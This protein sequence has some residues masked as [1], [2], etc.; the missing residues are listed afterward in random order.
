[1]IKEFFSAKLWHLFFRVRMLL[2]IPLFFTS[3][4]YAQEKTVTGSVSDITGMP[5][6]GVN[7][8]IKGTSNGVVSDISGN[9]TIKVP[10]NNA[11]LTFTYVGYENQEITVGEQSTIKV[12]LNEN[13]KELDQVVVIGYGTQKKS[14]LTGSVSSVT[15]KDIQAT[16]V[17]RIDQALEGRAAGVNVVSATGMPGG[18]SN[19]QIRGVSSINGFAPLVVIDGIPG[20]DM[21]KISP[22]DIESIEVLK[23]AAS[24]AIYGSNGGNGVILI[25]TKRGKA[26]SVTTRVNIY[27][28]IQQVEKTI[29]MMNTRQWNQLYTAMNG[30]PFIF[31]Q[32]SLNM[33]TDWQKAIY[34][35]AL[36]NN[37]DVNITGGNDRS[38]FSIGA[39]Y[40]KQEGLVRNTGYNR[41]LLSVSSLT[42]IAKH[43]K[44]DAVVRFSNDQTT[45]PA[46]WQYQNV[47]NNFTTFPALSMDPYLKPYDANGKWSVSPIGA[48]NPFVG[49]D[50]K[51]DQ[52]GKDANI[53]GNVGLNIEFIKGL[54]YTLRLSG[55]EDN[56]ESWN[57]QPEYFSWANDA[58]PM[59]KLTQNWDKG[60]SWTIQN[61]AT[62]NKTILDD[63]NISLMAGMESSD[64]W[65]YHMNGFRQDFASSNPNLLY[66]DNSLDLSSTSQIIGGS[67]K[68]ATSAAYYGRINYDYKSMILAQ[69][70]ARRDGESNFGPYDKWGNFYSGSVGFKFTEL[71]VVKDLNIFSFGKIR[72]GVGQSGQFQG[73]SYWPYASTILS[74]DVMDY[75]FDN[76][77]LSS[78]FAP[79]QVPNPSLHWETV[80]TKNFGA[81]LGFFKDQ[82]NISIDYF[83][84]DNTNMIQIQHVNDVAGTFYISAGGAEF[85]NTG[86][87]STYPSVNFGSVSNKGIELTLDYKKVIGDVKINFGVNLTYQVN[88]ITELATD[89]VSQGAVHDLGGLTVSKVGEPIGEF[90]GYRFNGL[91]KQGDKMVYNNKSKKYVFADQ[92]YYVNG[93]DTSYA[94]AN[95]KAGDARWVDANHDGLLNGH[96][97]EYLGSYIPPYVFGFSL[98]MEY[99]GI[100]FSAFFQGVYGNQIFD[101]IKR[102]TY[103][104]E[105]SQNHAAEFANRYH[106]PVIYN[107]TT[108]DPGNTTSNMPNIGAQNWGTPSTLYIENGSY[109]RLRTLTLGYTLPVAW[110]SK[111][112][113]DKFRL[114]FIG[115]NLLTLTKYSGYDPEI[116]QSDP[117][118][119]GIDIGGYPQARMYTFGVNI[120][121]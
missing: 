62:Y 98:G 94:Q 35:T 116:S 100:D 75:A 65:D 86:I 64:W 46:E 79:V 118:L 117:K 36:Q 41:L 9:F 95:A 11:I 91:F 22:S 15:S 71:Q 105:T 84:K 101:G 87:Q 77:T 59:S 55:T 80:T 28:G 4:L 7:V 31:S 120:D 74:V 90:T 121:F 66:F 83:T 63:H 32:D 34:R 24:A 10:D 50:E 37:C 14:D 102:F 60:Y 8:V 73:L 49:I 45:G 23:D 6:P 43:V 47:Y 97:R 33:N 68:E 42:N 1:M 18:S 110:T 92:I 19:I 2:L 48:M 81:D 38:Q 89:S 99:K 114:Y 111:V 112:G 107:G 113:I 69:F 40:L 70:N 57:F 3:A 96:D 16:P 44:L 109:L 51:S 54:T 21:N 12:V 85:G 115:R 106:L 58:N 104:W 108:I 103:T 78:G 39:N 52:K 25:T 53:Q 82:L 76:K 26:G 20:G 5:L 72:F 93:S 13:V 56:N 30:K 88:K 67:A 119:A 17:T 27:T 61:Y 29:P